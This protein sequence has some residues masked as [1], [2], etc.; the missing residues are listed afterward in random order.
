[1]SEQPAAVSAQDVT[2]TRIVATLIDFVLFF[3]LFIIMSV[4]L[5][6]SSARDSGNGFSVSLNGAPFIL[7]ILLVLGYSFLLEWLRGQTLGKML[8]GL[9]V[10]AVEGELTAQ[11]V[12]IR[13]ALRIVDALPFFYVLG[14]IVMVTSAR[15]QRLGDMAAGTVVVKA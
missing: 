14:F 15:K 3:V 6:D 5:G 12:F 2:G 1:M 7:Y 10:V 13:T 11:K 9:R 4:Q 8:M